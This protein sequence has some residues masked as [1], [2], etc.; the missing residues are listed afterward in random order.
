MASI[1]KRK[2]KYQAQIRR[3]GFSPITRSFFRLK[4]AQQWVRQNEIR[5]D[6]NEMPTDRKQLSSITLSDLV[7]RYRDEVLPIKKGLDF[8]TIILN[9]F[10]RHSICRRTLSNIS[11]A[12]FADYRDQKLK[13]ISAVSLKRYLAVIHNMFEVAK[14]EWGVDFHAE[15]TRLGV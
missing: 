1:R 11:T 12:D 4:D 8:E 13:Q 5:L 3:T 7:K 9:A 10:L 14:Y 15:V 2:N 6:R